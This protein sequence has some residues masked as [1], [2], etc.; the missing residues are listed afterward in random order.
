MLYDCFLITSTQNSFCLYLF[1]RVNMMGTWVN[2]LAPRRKIALHVFP[3][4]TATCYLTGS[5][6][7]GY[8]L[9]L[10]RTVFSMIVQSQL[11]FCIFI[12]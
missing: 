6:S 7:N 5:L 4:D 10:N 3:K 11:L 9:M 8:Y 1:C 12:E 2:Y